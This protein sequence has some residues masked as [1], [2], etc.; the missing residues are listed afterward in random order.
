MAMELK[1]TDNPQYVEIHDETGHIGDIRYVAADPEDPTEGW[2][3]DFEPFNG[4]SR[5][6]DYLP[7]AAEAFAAA[8]PLYEELV[9]E[10]QRVARFYRNQNTRAISIPTGGQPKK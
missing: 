10:R 7:T 3:A 2:I 1:H 8:W 6:T 5:Q 9:K 4:I